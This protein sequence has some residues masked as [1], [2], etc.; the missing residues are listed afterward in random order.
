VSQS[1]IQ[2]FIWWYCAALQLGN[3]GV[4]AAGAAGAWTVKKK[5]IAGNAIRRELGRS[6][7]FMGLPFLVSLAAGG[8]VAFW[9]SP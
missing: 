5:A 6:V 2:K 4:A 7:V 9:M 3:V 1:P 8:L